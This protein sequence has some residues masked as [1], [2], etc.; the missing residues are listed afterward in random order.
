MLPFVLGWMIWSGGRRFSGGDEHLMY[1]VDYAGY[2]I[3]NVT[4]SNLSDVLYKNIGALVA[5]VAAIIVPA[6][7]SHFSTVLAATIAVGALVGAY[8]LARDREQARPYALYSAGL[9]AMLVVWHYPPNSR[10]VFPLFPILIAGFAYQM[11]ATLA[12][13]RHAYADS[14]QKRSAVI[15]ASVLLALAIPVLW[16]NYDFSFDTAPSTRRNQVLTMGDDVFCAQRMRS[17]L[18]AEARIMAPNDPT[19]YLLTGSPSISMAVAP[20][21]WYA[22]GFERMLEQHARL[23]EVARE[24]G[25]THLYVNRRHRWVLTEKEHERLFAMFANSPALKPVMQCGSVITVYEI[26]AAKA[27]L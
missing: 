3:L 7:E 26:N 13:L 25:M 19:M 6:P 20:R 12:I 4:L 11:Q 10:F 5:G 21:Y 27:V 14:K 18:P 2:Q 22:G 8:R 24:H 23:P 9:M 1:Y 17:E 16:N 15:F